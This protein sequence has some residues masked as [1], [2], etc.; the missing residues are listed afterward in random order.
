MNLSKQIGSHWRSEWIFARVQAVHRVPSSHRQGVLIGILSLAF[1]V[2]SLKPALAEAVKPLLPVTTAAAKANSPS[3]AQ[4]PMAATNSLSV[5]PLP[6]IAPEVGPLI[7]NQYPD[8]INRRTTAFI[9]Q[10]LD[11]LTPIQLPE[12][13]GKWIR[14]DLSKQLVVAY[15]GKMP[16]RAFRVSSGLPGTPTVT[17]TFHIRAKVVSQTMKGGEGAMH[18]DLPGVKWVQY[19]Y[20]GYSF[21]GTY[22]HSN[23]GH[24]MSHGCLNMTN[25]DAKWLFDWATPTWDGKTVS[26]KS[27]SDTAGTLVVIH[28]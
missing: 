24:P 19:F 17:G 28:E 21:H 4:P 14:V 25:A 27:P 5:P 7:K 22:W 26:F 2:S 23:F 12:T 13:D 3:L 15:E 10:S 18:Y 9:P 6:F 20:E 16:I 11:D 1:F 8:D